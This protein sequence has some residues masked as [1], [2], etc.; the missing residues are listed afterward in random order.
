MAAI[1]PKNTDAILVNTIT[2]KNAGSGVT[3]GPIAK[4]DTLV[5]KTGGV[6]VSLASILK[7]LNVLIPLTA[8]VDLGTT[9]AAE[10]IREAFIKKITSNGQDLT[11]ETTS[12]NDIVIKLNSNTIFT[13]VQATGNLDSN[14]TNGADIRFLK[15]GT[16]IC[17][18]GDATFTTLGTTQAAATPITKINTVITT[19]T[20]GATDGALLPEITAA[21]LW[22]PR[23]VLN[24]SGAAAKVYPFLGANIDDAAA[25]AAYSLADNL[26]RT[27]LPITTTRWL[28]F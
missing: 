20:A 4:A 18:N 2:E 22:K 7:F 19:C 28:S 1:Q 5:E 8:T 16:G 12:A 27:F 15:A 10:H 14:V 9:T 13:L 11:I 25:N 17:E 24:E 3:I 21:N 6:G 23:R 26:R